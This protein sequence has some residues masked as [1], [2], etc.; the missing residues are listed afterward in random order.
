MAS[1]RVLFWSVIAFM[2]LVLSFY[3][4]VGVIDA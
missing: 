3:L 4:V 2:T 1:Q